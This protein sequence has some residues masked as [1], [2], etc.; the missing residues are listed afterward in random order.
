MHESSLHSWCE[1]SFVI[2]E[3]VQKVRYLSSR[4][5]ILNLG[6][7][8]TRHV[9]EIF[10]LWLHWCGG[11][12]LIIRHFNKVF[13]LR[14]ILIYKSFVSHWVLLNTVERSNCGQQLAGFSS[15]LHDVLNGGRLRDVIAS[16]ESALVACLDVRLVQTISLFHNL[17]L[18]NSQIGHKLTA[19]KID[20]LSVIVV[21]FLIV[22]SRGLV[23][24]LLFKTVN[25]LVCVFFSSQQTIKVFNSIWCV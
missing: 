5:E 23:N 4:I 2:R 12:V 25:R 15:S 16:L 1:F 8:F 20:I 17:A 22:N 24:V 18:R 10:F 3:H 9:F 6:R 7:F 11:S 19:L 21:N 14:D 13:L